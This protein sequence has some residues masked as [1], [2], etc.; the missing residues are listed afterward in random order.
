MPDPA[1]LDYVASPLGRTRETMEILRRTLGLDPAG[2]RQDQRFVELT[3]G[4]WEGLTWREVR[5][6]AASLA[7]ARERDKWSFVPPGGESYAMLFDRLL[8]A[9]RELQRPTVLVSHGGVARALLAALANV[10]QHEAP[11]LDIWQGRVLV[12]EDGG[13]RWV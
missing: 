13:Y 5:G 2:Y 9:A 3:F 12:F 1:S 10:P 7:A 6:R 8:P 4:N 11:R